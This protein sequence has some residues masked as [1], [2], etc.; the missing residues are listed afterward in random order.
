MT[1]FTRMAKSEEGAF[2]KAYPADG[3]LY[4]QKGEE[5]SIDERAKL[6]KKG[7]AMSDGSFPIRNSTDLKHAIDD[8]GRAGSKPTVKEHIIQRAK[9]LDLT[10]SLPDGWVPAGGSNTDTN[11]DTTAK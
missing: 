2:A 5:F 10:G 4:F 3:D 6:A 7:A 8:W 1:Q 9:D 11:T